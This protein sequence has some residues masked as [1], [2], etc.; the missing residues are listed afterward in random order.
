MRLIG[1]IFLLLAFASLAYTFRSEESRTDFYRKISS[2][3]KNL[4]VYKE[5]ARIK[6]LRWKSKKRE[7]ILS[8]DERKGIFYV[9]PKWWAKL[10]KKEKKDSAFF[11]YIYLQSK[12]D[13][14]IR[15]IEIWGS[16]GTSK[17]LLAKYG[18]RTGYK[19]FVDI[20]DGWIEKLGK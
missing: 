7:Y 1:W 10:N 13:R 4:R 19:D 15:K 3:E 2:N 8:L 18:G 11:M 6:V 5:E 14:K 17:V 12:D 9:S 16:K 20:E